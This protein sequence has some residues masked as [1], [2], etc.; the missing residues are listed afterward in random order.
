MSKSTLKVDLLIFSQFPY[1]NL[2]KSDFMRKLF[3]LPS[4]SN[5]KKIFY[6]LNALDKKLNIE[7]ST[8]EYYQQQKIFLINQMF[9]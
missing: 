1:L 7:K 8:L 3:H 5:Q 2:Q 6:T 4:K 9:I